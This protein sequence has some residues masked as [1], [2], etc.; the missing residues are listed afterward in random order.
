MKK[1]IAFAIPIVFLLIFIVVFAIVQ[2]NQPQDWES[3]LERYLAHQ[4]VFTNT[5]LNVQTVSKAQF[6]WNFTENMSIAALAES[7]HFDTIGYKTSVIPT[8]T[9]DFIP[10]GASG[11]GKAPLPY[12]PVDLWCVVLAQNGNGQKLV[13]VALHQ[14]LYNAEI[15]VHE[16]S[17]KI[18]SPT[19][20]ASLIEIGCELP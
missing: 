3:A 2:A 10:E 12:P 1:A 8:E 6:P 17:G 9:A 20:Q 7:V 16:P 5:E 18:E 19:L 15:V 13:F 4:R 14:D 11:S